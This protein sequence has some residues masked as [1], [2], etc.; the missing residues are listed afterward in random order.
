MA[1]SQDPE[2]ADV[3]PIPQDD[4]PEPIVPIVYPRGFVEVHDYFRA[5]LKSNEKSERALKLTERALAFNAANYTAWTFRRQCL[6]ALK[7]DLTKELVWSADLALATPKNYQLWHHRRELV[8]ITG[9]SSH[10]LELVRKVLEAEG[11]AKNYHAW[12]HRQWVLSKFGMWDDELTY[13]DLL[14]AEDV[15]NNSAWNHRCFV[16]ERTT[17]FGLDILSEEWR[18]V[19]TALDKA[20]HNDSTWNYLVGLFRWPEMTALHGDIEGYCLGVLAEDDG[21]CQAAGCLVELYDRQ[22][23]TD[24]KAEEKLKKMCKFLSKL[25]AIHTKYWEFRFSQLSTPL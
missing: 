4:G 23:C 10:E 6:V 1:L 18:Y 8:S 13:I 16:L 11:D 15:R 21:C 3:V 17:G 20:P 24:L 9:D 2:W 22:R 12:S 25:D 19:R 7:A 14:L 5:I